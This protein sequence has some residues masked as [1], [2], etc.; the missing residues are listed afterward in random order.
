MNIEFILLIILS[1]IITFFIKN[2]AINNNLIDVPN[3]RSSHSTPTPRGG[4]V[5]IVICYL[6]FLIYLYFSK[7]IDSQIFIGFSVS[8]LLVAV[9]GF[10]DDHQDLSAK[11]RLL[12]HFIAAGILVYF[13]GGLPDIEFAGVLFNLGWMGTVFVIFFIVWMIN[14]YNFMDGIDGLAASEI[15]ISSTVMGLLALIYYQNT[16]LA[17]LA[18]GLAC[19]AIGFLFLNF[20]PAKIFMGDAG[21]GFLGITAI[22]LILFFGQVDQ[23]LIWAWGIMLSVF[24][25]DASFTLS[26]RMLK[27]HSVSEAHRNHA[28]QKASRK[29]NSHKT[30]TISIAAINIIWLAPLAFLTVAG[31]IDGFF[32]LLIAYTPIILLAIYFKAGQSD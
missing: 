31:F 22:S 6:L 26:Q 24:I 5:A 25:V 15:I 14:L 7:T 12:V 27:K 8:S 20:P 29:F 18:W 10:M 28:Y 23:S 32:A 3:Q 16:P 1:L 30:V 4:G 11:V 2:Y 17:Y 9:I 13:S 21:S 19:S